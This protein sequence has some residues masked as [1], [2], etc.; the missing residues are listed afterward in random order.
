M[1]AKRAC[2]RE[3]P[4]MPLVRVLDFEI[5]LLRWVTIGWVEVETHGVVG[6]EES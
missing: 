1:Y 6:K 2:E 3:Y 5:P 4:T